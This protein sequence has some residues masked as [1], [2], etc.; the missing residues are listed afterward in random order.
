MSAR[1]NMGQDV[2]RDKVEA[3]GVQNNNVMGL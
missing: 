2:T 1:D 3:H